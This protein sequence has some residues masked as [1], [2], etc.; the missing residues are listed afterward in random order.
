[1]PT[2]ARD[3]HWETLAERLGNL[4]GDSIEVGVHPGL[5]DEWR[6]REQAGLEPFVAA[7]VRAGHSLVGWNDI[8]VG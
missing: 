7:A 6:R 8:A 5:R 3:R 4:S 1:M 2:S